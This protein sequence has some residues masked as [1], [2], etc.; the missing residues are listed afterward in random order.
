M[1]QLQLFGCW[2]REENPKEHRSD[3]IWV[4]HNTFQSLSHRGVVVPKLLQVV[5]ELKT[6]SPYAS[7]PSAELT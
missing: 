7:T 6:P 2:T 1:I 5:L 4:D 3:K